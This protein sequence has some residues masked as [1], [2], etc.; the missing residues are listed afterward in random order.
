MTC[1][2]L[3]EFDFPMWVHVALMLTGQHLQNCPVSEFPV[4]LY[5]FMFTHRLYKRTGRSHPDVT[6]SFFGLPFWSL[7]FGILAVAILIF[8][9][10]EVTIFG[11]EDGAGEEWGVSEVISPR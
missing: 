7:E 1:S 9:E 10:P 8:L 3:V 11:W 2:Q 4:S 5:N 6:H